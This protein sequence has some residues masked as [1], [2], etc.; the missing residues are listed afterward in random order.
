MTRFGVRHT[1]ML[2]LGAAA[3]SFGCAREQG[4]ALDRDAFYRPPQG[5]DT[6]RHVLQDQ[7][8][9]LMY[10]NVR[11]NLL[12]PNEGVQVLNPE[13]DAPRESVTSVS[14]AV[15][16]NVE[17]PSSTG[18]RAPSTSPATM[19]AGVSS[20]VA[21]TIGA[22]V[23]EVNGTP[24]YADKVLASL[25]RVFAAEA[26]RLDERGFRAFAK[27][28]IDKQVRLFVRTELAFAAAKRNLDAREQDLASAMTMQWRAR[29]ITE[30][31][32]SIERARARAEAEGYSF[33][34]RAEEEYRNNMVRVYYQKRL[35][36]RTQVRADEMRR[37][38]DANRD[39]LFT[40]RDE[41]TFRLIK[42]DAKRTGGAEA[43]QRKAQEVRDRAARGED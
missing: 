29:Q 17:L 32:G 16:E 40:E 18:D 25:S 8:G 15:R 26:K 39:K 43:A 7:P 35:F 9:P 10:D 36:P 20:G 38:Y 28:E 34:E 1:L 31:G 22:V 3:A 37:Y 27:S 33:D 2:A 4:T 12:A 41:A 6:R 19:P 42:I 11:V 21:M 14:E 24:V 23:C 13:E 5:R 30:A